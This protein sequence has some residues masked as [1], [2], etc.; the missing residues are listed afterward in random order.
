ML[1]ILI[2]I[3]MTPVLMILMGYAMLFGLL[4]LTNI[5]RCLLGG[6]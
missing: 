5:V 2:W 3:V 1:M 6:D 4:I